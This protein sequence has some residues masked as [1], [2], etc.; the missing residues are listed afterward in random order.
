MTPKRKGNGIWQ[1]GCAIWAFPTAYS[2][3]VAHPKRNMP[4]PNRLPQE[5]AELPQLLNPMPRYLATL[6]AEV[7]VAVNLE[8]V[9]GVEDF[10]C[11][12]N[13]VMH[14]HR[15]KYDL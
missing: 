15:C 5:S 12:P 6:G 14:G 7:E 4:P 8:V 13:G 10:P 9:G 2:A 3:Q 1:P 11:D